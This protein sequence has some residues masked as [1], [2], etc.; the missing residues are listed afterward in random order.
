V[1]V[2]YLLASWETVRVFLETAAWSYLGIFMTLKIGLSV[3]L[4]CGPERR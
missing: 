2:S 3:Q 1:G 4:N